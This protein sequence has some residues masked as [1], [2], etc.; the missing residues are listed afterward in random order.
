MWSH[1]VA[2]V[3]TVELF[4][5]IYGILLDE[6]DVVV[7]VNAQLP[8]KTLLQSVSGSLTGRQ[9]SYFFVV[10]NESKSA[11]HEPDLHKSNQ[12]HLVLSSSGVAVNIT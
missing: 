4:L 12:N 10:D 3:C 5:S 1:V 6:G 2:A 7:V 11:G 8:W 9:Q